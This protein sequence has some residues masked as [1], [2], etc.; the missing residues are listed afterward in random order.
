MTKDA[1]GPIVVREDHAVPDHDELA[2]H[3]PIR[4]RYL[5]ALHNQAIL[6]P[7]GASPQRKSVAKPSVPDQSALS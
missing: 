2:V 6:C 5:W 1:L 7:S 3:R 4:S